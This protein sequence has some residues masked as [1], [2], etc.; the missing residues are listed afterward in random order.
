MAT[1]EYMLLCERAYV[2]N[3][4]P[5]IVKVLDWIGGP[6]FPLRCD[7]FVAIQLRGAPHEVMPFLIQVDDPHG[8]IVAAGG[9]QAES[10]A[11]E[12]GGLFVP[13]PLSGITF[14]QPGQHTVKV[15]VHDRVLF[16]R[17]LHLILQPGGAQQP[18]STAH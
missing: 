14:T 3:G 12:H 18:P 10:R 1:V 2:D 6:T 17:P 16:Q 11:S 9:R 5:C 13:F 7:L 8:N 4:M 15:S